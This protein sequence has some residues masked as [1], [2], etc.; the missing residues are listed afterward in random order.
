MEEKKRIRVVV[1]GGTACHL[2]GGTGLQLLGEGL[3]EAVRGR[4]E[5]VGSPCLDLCRS[6]SGRRPPFVRIDG[7]DVAAASVDDVVERVQQRL[8]REGG[9]Q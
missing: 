1:C 7:E 6:R 5:V 8:G 2:L 4:V 3:P 9:E